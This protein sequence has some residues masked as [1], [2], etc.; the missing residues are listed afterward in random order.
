MFR[1]NGDIIRQLEKIYK[2]KFNY[3]NKEHLK[4]SI[5]SFIDFKL[6][7]LNLTNFSDL[8]FYIK[9]NKLFEIYDNNINSIS[10]KFLI[11]NKNQ[12]LGFFNP[13]WYYEDK[14]NSVKLTLKEKK[15]LSSCYMHTIILEEYKDLMETINIDELS[16]FLRSYNNTI[17][18]KNNIKN[19][20]EGI[21]TSYAFFYS[22]EGF[23]FLSSLSV[24]KQK[25][26]LNKFIEK[27]KN[28]IQIEINYKEH[29]VLAIPLKLE[30]H[31]LIEKSIKLER[32]EINNN[33]LINEEWNLIY[34]IGLESISF[35]KDI[36]SKNI[37]IK[38]VKDPLLS[39][40]IFYEANT[41][42]NFLLLEK[43]YKRLH[44]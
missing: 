12:L 34:K 17:D 33:E 40:L 44:F 38:E 35:R 39:S 22:K 19:I 21:L 32:Y 4:Q 24:I 42:F 1:L 10:E 29:D 11:E 8:L 2:F 6:R 43:I 37:T 3:K 27:N 20:L 23:D 14:E 26:L 25:Q 18:F 36:T 15:K 5:L 16:S 28:S 31:K 7:D 13:E 30:N 9:E 41:F